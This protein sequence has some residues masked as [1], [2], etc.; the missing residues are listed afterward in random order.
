[1]F[2]PVNGN[3]GSWPLAEVP[4]PVAVEELE[5]LVEVVDVCESVEL[6]VDDEPEPDDPVE[7]DDWLE[8]DPVEPEPDEP[9]GCGVVD[10]PVSGSTYC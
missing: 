6:L 4:L 7:P 8:P 1:M 10:D 2:S 3:V 5:L 9:L